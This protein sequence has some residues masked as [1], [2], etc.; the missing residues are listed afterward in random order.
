MEECRANVVCK[1][2][3]IDEKD[4][5]AIIYYLFKNEGYDEELEEHRAL[6]DPGDWNDS[7]GCSGGRCLAD[8][9]KLSSELRRLLIWS[10]IRLI[11]LGFDD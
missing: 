9:L 7:D 5:D 3:S 11:C 10:Y 2:I 1:R 6:C 4:H 8:V